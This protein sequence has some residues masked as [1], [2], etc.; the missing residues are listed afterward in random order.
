VC[1]QPGGKRSLDLEVFLEREKSLKLEVERLGKSR[2]QI[3]REVER[4]REENLTQ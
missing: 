3:Q 1:Y 2:D 4:N